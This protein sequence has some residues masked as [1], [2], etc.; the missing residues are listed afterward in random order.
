MDG[1]AFRHAE[2]AQLLTISA[3][4]LAGH[5]SPDSAGA[6]ECH[7]V[8]TGARVPDFADTVV[9]Q[10]NV[11]L[12]DNTMVIKKVPVLAHH[13]RVAGSDSPKGSKLMAAGQYLG[14]AQIATLN[15]HGIANVSVL[16]KLKLAVFS[17]GDELVEPG[18][19][20]PPGSIYESNRALISSLLS[21]NA[22]DVIDIGIVKDSMDAL[23]EAFAKSAKADLIVSSGG[24]SVG[25]ADYVRPVLEETGTL[26]MWKIAMKPGRPLTFGMLQNNRPYFGLPGNPVSSAVTCMM[27]VLPTLRA[28]LSMPPKSIPKLQATLETALTKLPGRVE[29]QRG[30]L[31]Q[32][33][34][35]RWNV[36][37]TGLQDSHVIT[38]LHKANCFVELGMNS[39]GAESGEKVYV[40]P[41]EHFSESLL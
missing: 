39:A 37:T 33:E 5:P 24:V 41:F 34:N 13:V 9:Q 35:G 31:T 21:S 29:Y 7:R 36:S 27:F 20:L 12:T 30:V 25:D 2:H 10:E 26:H 23:R 14:A 11:E 15:S 4:S 19:D 32:D 1:Y 22:V 3:Q 6:M 8:T 18:N 38:S 28:M 40:L 17:T 16:R